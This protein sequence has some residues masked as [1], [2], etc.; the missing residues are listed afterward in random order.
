[1]SGSS[2]P[3]GRALLVALIPE[4]RA[5]LGAH[6]REITRVPYRVGRESRGTQRPPADSSPSDPIMD[7]AQQR[8]R[9]ARR[10]SNLR[11][12]DQGTAQK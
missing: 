2:A 9:I 11:K 5:A 7:L 12:A 6:E 3:H 1:V 8:L 10:K 4:S